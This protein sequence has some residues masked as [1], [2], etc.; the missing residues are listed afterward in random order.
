MMGNDV[1]IITGIVLYFL[2]LGFML[3]FIHADFNQPEST[4][5]TEDFQGEIGQEDVSATDVMFSIFSMFF[6]SFGSLAPWFDLTF[7]M[8]VRIALAILIF[9]QIRSGAG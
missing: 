8:A 9:R 7:M 2:I 1:E 4:I 3:P 5:N 6:W